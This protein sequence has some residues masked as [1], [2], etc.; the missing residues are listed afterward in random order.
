MWR[1]AGPNASL[2]RAQSLFPWR[3]R[4][5]DFDNDSPFMNDL[6]ALA[7]PGAISISGQ[8]SG[9]R[10]GMPIATAR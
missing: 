10:A 3:I 4:G 1:P 9:L 5:L 8:V 7:H 6:P 2:E